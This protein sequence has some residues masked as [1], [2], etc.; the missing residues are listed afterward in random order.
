MMIS[1]LEKPW[2]ES[3]EIP[4]DLNNSRQLELAKALGDIEGS[5]KIVDSRYFIS[6]DRPT[7]DAVRKFVGGKLEGPGAFK[8]AKKIFDGGT[9][10][11]VI[12]FASGFINKE[13]IAVAMDY[14]PIDGKWLLAYFSLEK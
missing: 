10:F 6:P 14:E 5:W 2:V 12:I 9:R 11:V 3:Q 8:K 7:W 4:M 1:Q 13:Y